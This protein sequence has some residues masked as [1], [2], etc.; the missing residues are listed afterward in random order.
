MRRT[1]LGTLYVVATPIGNL[2]D[3]SLRAVEVLKH[4]DCIAAEDTRHS[5]RL[6]MHFGIQQRLVSLHEF[7]ENK[8]VEEMMRRL[9]A[10]E[11][12]ALISDAGTPLISDPGFPVV[13]AAHAARIPVIPIPGPCAA[14]AALSASGLPTHHFVFEGFLPPKGE[15]RLKRLQTLALETRTLIFYEAVH[16]IENLLQLLVEKF[17]SDR[18]A[19]VARELTKKYETVRQ[20]PL[21]ELLHI[22]QQPEQQKGEYVI[23]VAGASEKSPTSETECHHLLEILLSEVSLKQAVKLAQKITGESRQK[24]YD[25]AL[26]ITQKAKIKPSGDR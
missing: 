15:K 4:V 11:N 8:R 2:Q 16:R 18:M 23:I 14:I 19:C 24:L 26:K 17:G 3:M 7:N 25:G 1:D 6:L 20:A 5:Q 13:A 10:G 12:V 22:I 9:T 21:G